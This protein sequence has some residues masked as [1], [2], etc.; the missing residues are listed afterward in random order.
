MRWFRPP[1]I[2]VRPNW[3]SW[4][5]KVRACPPSAAC[6]PAWPSWTGAGGKRWRGR[7]HRHRNRRCFVSELPSCV[8]NTPAARHTPAPGPQNSGRS[9]T[10]ASFCPHHPRN[11]KGDRRVNQKT[12]TK[13]ESASPFGS[14]WRKQGMSRLCEKPP[15]F[16][17]DWSGSRLSSSN[18]SRTCTAPLLAT[19]HA[20]RSSSLNQL[21]GCTAHATLGSPHTPNSHP[22]TQVSIQAY[23][24]TH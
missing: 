1:A 8:R 17:P 20:A 3:R 24:Q 12:T 19:S 6:R 7:A 15:V 9:N 13:F 14:C 4:G 16:V 11:R 5:A 23:M 2:C 22:R 18:T 21:Q 10:L